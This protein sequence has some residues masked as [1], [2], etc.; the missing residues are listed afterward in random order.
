M[1]DAFKRQMDDMEPRRRPF[2]IVKTEVLR[3]KHFEMMVQ[4]SNTERYIH[5]LVLFGSILLLVVFL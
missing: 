3:D 1:V 5:Y 4:E 2:R